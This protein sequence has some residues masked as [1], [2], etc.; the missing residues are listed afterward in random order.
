MALFKRS[1][2]GLIVTYLHFLFFVVIFQSFVDNNLAQRL[3]ANNNIHTQ[4]GFKTSC[5]KQ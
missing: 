4:Q 3:L 1:I 2:L 5:E